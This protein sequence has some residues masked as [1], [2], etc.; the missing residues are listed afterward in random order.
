M[1]KEIISVILAAGESKAMKSDIPRAVFPVLGKP[2]A[3]YAVKAASEAG[4]KKNVMVVG[5]GADKVREAFGESV[6]YADQPETVGTSDAVAHARG[7]FE[8]TD[9]YV[10]VLPGDAPLI[11]AQTL[12]GAIKYHEE[13]K[14]EATIITA[15][16]NNP[17]GYG[18]IIPQQRGRRCVDCGRKARKPKRAGNQ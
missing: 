6:C 5:F 11:D 12:Q 7:Y 15:I 16:V 2:M 14:N 17:A 1:S 8:Q 10:L 3:S 9:A 18:R 4:A 13:F